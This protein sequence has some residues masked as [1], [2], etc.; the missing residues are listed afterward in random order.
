MTTTEEHQV[1]GDTA[2]LR[3]LTDALRRVRR[4]DLKVR[5]PRRS[6]ATG[7]VAEAF[8]EVVQLQE[9]QT[10]NVRKISRIV[11]RDGKL[12]ERLDEEG[13]DGAWG[14]AARAVNML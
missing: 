4:G 5:L 9:R 12:T 2:L 3:E 1:T 7:E 6:G 11:G 10:L 8:N 14:D 13:L